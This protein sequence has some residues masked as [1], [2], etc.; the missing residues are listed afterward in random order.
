[1]SVA[2]FGQDLRY[3]VRVLLGNLRYTIAALF[4]LGLGIGTNTAVF[5][6]YKAMVARP[7]ETAPA[8]GQGPMVNLALTRQNGTTDFT[9][10]YPDYLAY[11]D[12]VR[13]FRDVIAFNGERMTLSS[14]GGRAAA[15]DTLIER[16]GIVS[17]STRN[18]EAAS[19]FVVSENYF[20][21][22]GV[23]A[24]RG[25][26]LDPTDATAHADA[27]PVVVSEGYWRRRFGSDASLV[28]RTVRLN[29]ATVTIVGITP[30]Q[31]VGTSIAA[32]DF[33][34]P[35][36]LEPVVHADDTWLRNREHAFCRLFARLAP[37]GT[38]GEAQA[39][40]TTVVDRVRAQHDPHA[41]GA[42]PAMALVF[43]GSPFPLPLN[44]YAGL[45]VTILLV[46]AAAALVLVVSCANVASLQL[47]RAAAR[48]TE[49]RTRLSLGATRFRL[50]RQLLT[51]S[52]LLGVVAGAIALAIAWALLRVA[53]ALVADALPIEFGSLVFNVTPDL[54]IFGFV[55]AVSF[56]AAILFGLVPAL[57]GS[58]SALATA[59]RSSTSSRRTRR[60]QNTLV[61]SQVALSL[62]LA[63]AGSVLIHG[64]RESLSRDTGY[65]VAHVAD[66]EFQFPEA[67]RY[68]DGRKAALVD[69]IRARAA[70]LPGVVSVT[71]ARPPDDNRV[72]TPAVALDDA[73]S[74]AG[75]APT[76][77]YYRFIE[78][79][80]FETVRI[81]VLLGRG[82]HDA[83]ESAGTAVISESTARRLWPGQNP[84]GRRVRLGVTDEQGRL[85]LQIDRAAEGL[86]YEIVGVARDTRGVAFD[87]SDARQ[88]YLL[89][90]ASQRAS[91]G[92]LI[93]SAL[94][95]NS[96]LRQLDPLVTAVDPDL[97]PTISTLQDRLRRS[98]PFIVASLSAAIASSLGLLGLLLAAMGIYGTV[99]YMVARRTREV[100]IRMAIG[101]QKRDIVTLIL[102]ESARPVL[103]GLAIGLGITAAVL[104]LLDGVFFGLG[105]MDV[106]SLG[107]VTSLFLAIALL[108][109]Y[110]PSR[111]ALRVN[112]IDALRID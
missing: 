77:L 2:A 40:M 108:A 66:L 75:K 6:A 100:G 94:D 10:S 4:A 15:S 57:D 30:A 3:G 1:M 85:L 92:I 37:G 107:G 68:S 62:M 86:A 18:A 111:R 74:A 38:I 7:L 55:L 70:A 28:G 39:E 78:P 43:P 71:S 17:A 79:T 50:I 26:T 106:T 99:S 5:T 112:P 31:F 89:E 23:Q 41:D 110:P 60:L 102:G 27:P 58:R 51:E 32:P 25:R 64:A 73:S 46:M 44:L 72:V 52:V 22:F 95:A 96:L 11:R 105:T 56:V 45:R 82:F 35:M 88:I 16:L 87:G 80:Y 84:I 63:I 24:L 29:G 91:R 34:I 103:A 9:F 98:A 8:R 101:A 14:A 93:R 53:V 13:A 49:L 61:A 83:G 47:A 81:P 76:L 109:A 65:D 36:S 19:V 67:A 33:W 20:R 59:T 42:R 97:V 104:R 12:D 69:E 21:V 90:S 48:Q 54:E